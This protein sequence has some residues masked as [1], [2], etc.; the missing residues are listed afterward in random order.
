MRK[1][2]EEAHELI[3]LVVE[4]SHHHVAK[5]F[6]G[7]IAPSK[8]RMLDAKVVEPG[9]LFDKIEKLTKA[10]NLIMD[11]LKIR[12]GSKGLALLAQCSLSMFALLE[13]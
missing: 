4:N 8:G 5:S 10:Q 11:S 7:Q 3:E 9:M 13:F 6:G 2:E 12:S 1:Y